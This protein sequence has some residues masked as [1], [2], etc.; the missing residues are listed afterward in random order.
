MFSLLTLNYFTPFPSFPIVDFEQVNIFW[1]NYYMCFDMST[2]GKLDSTR[3]NARSYVNFL[4][5]H[6]QCNVTLVSLRFF[7]LFIQ[8]TLE[9]LYINATTEFWRHKNKA[10][11]CHESIYQDHFPFQKTIKLRRIK[12]F[13]KALYKTSVISI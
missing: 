13:Y 9:S 5:S 3:I 11:D 2:G 8:E 10:G 4:I 6:T 1:E 12:D 7:K